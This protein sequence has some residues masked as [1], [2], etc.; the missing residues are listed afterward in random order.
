MLF[1]SA[2]IALFGFEGNV[3]ILATMG[4]AGVVCC[5]TYTSGD[6]CQDLKTGS[7]VGA[8]PKR[9]QWAEVLGVVTAAFV[10][11]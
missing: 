6:V 7:L 11:G 5:A 4:V 8:T 3:A 2:F 10:T 1:T 9:Q